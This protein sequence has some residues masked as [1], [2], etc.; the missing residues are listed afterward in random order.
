MIPLHSRHWGCCQNCLWVHTCPQGHHRKC[1]PCAPSLGSLRHGRVL[2]ATTD[3]SWSS[4][5]R[6]NN[7]YM[8]YKPMSVCQLSNRGQTTSIQEIITPWNLAALQ[9][10]VHYA[11]LCQCL[12]SETDYQHSGN[13]AMNSGC[14]TTT[15][16]LC[17]PASVHQL[18]KRGQTTT[19][20]GRGEQ[21]TSSTYIQGLCFFVSVPQLKTWVR[22]KVVWA[23]VPPHL[24]TL[25]YTQV[26]FHSPLL[27]LHCN[28]GDLLQLTVFFTCQAKS[29]AS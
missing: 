2:G 23:N 19:M 17:K 15:D 18:W 13:N 7:K 5:P 29:S 8:L 26:Q 9:Q 25:L 10:Q 28:F 12:S 1:A 16:T 21:N 24:Y 11:N 4:W 22:I 6:C 20:S 14:I 27:Q 3:P